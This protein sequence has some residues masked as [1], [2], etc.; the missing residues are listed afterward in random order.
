L[1]LSSDETLMPISTFTRVASAWLTAAAAVC[2]WP[3]LSRA[4]DPTGPATKPATQ[5]I[6]LPAT[7]ESF[8]HADL[9]A[10]TAGYVTEVKADIGDHVKAGQVLAVIDNP[11]LA[12]ELAA[13]KATVRA[14]EQL[15]AASRAAVDQAQTALR[16]TKGQL[17]A[18]QAD[19]KLAQVTFK[20]QE[21]LF[22]GKA[23]TDQQLD[24]ARTKAEVAQAQLQVG[25]AKIAAAEADVRAA[26]ANQAVAAA[27]VDVAGAEAGRLEALLSYTRITAPF[28][29]V[30]SKRMVNRGDLTQSGAA[31]RTTP[32]FT[33]QGLDTVRVACEVPEL[34]AVRVAAG[35]PASIKVFGPDGQTIDAK[36]TRAAT[37]LD[38]DTR[39]MRVEVHLPNP[40]ERLRPGMYVQVTLTL[41]SPAPPTTAAATRP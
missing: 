6:D 10:K 8:E 29:G 11:E 39:T 2:V 41:R 21:D 35:T 27:Q 4:A 14:K 30:V 13:A 32:L 34:N 9:Y 31:T 37:T 3:A 7:V 33:V 22:Q 36:V 5:T 24:D 23:I 15:A 20:R 38:P 1:T 17:V 16:V 25:E 19:L 26:E 28:D 12:R 18:Y 40:E